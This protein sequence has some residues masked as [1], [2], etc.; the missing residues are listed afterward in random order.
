MFFFLGGWVIVAMYVCRRVT[1]RGFAGVLLTKIRG[2]A[3]SK[4]KGTLD[5]DTGRREAG[6][7]KELLRV[8]M[9]V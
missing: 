6:E 7:R 2:V 1:S 3:C 4:E 9:Y 5:T 8:C